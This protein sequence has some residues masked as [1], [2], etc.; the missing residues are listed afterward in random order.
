[1]MNIKRIAYIIW[2]VSMMCTGALVASMAV[3]F[4]AAFQNEAASSALFGWIGFKVLYVKMSSLLLAYA[5]ASQISIVIHQLGNDER[6]GFVAWI[7]PLVSVAAMIMCDLIIFA[8]PVSALPSY[9][10]W[11]YVILMAL[12][13]EGTRENSLRIFQEMTKDDEIPIW[14]F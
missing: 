10:I 14:K 2:G 12:L 4:N 3:G 9:L 11:A 7:M 13:F 1:M 5:G 6:P 8:H